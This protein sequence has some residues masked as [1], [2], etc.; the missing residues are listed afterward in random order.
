MGMFEGE[1]W[2][3]PTRCSLLGAVPG[4]KCAHNSIQVYLR[5]T[6]LI[7][8]NSKSRI[9]PVFAQL[10]TSRWEK[11]IHLT[12]IHALFTDTVLLGQASWPNHYP[13][14]FNFFFVVNRLFG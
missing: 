6:Q 7:D 13:A 9:E 3:D 14:F 1:E 11:H 5:G 2:K 4:V 8:S 12:N 10:E